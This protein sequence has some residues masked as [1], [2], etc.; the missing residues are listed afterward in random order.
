MS[1]YSVLWDPPTYYPSLGCVDQVNSW[2]W[3]P[4]NGSGASRAA[5]WPSSGNL[6]ENPNSIFESALIDWWAENLIDDFIAYEVPHSGYSLYWDWGEASDGWNV[7]V[8]YDF[9]SYQSYTG[10]G[11]EMHL[12]YCPDDGELTSESSSSSSSTE[13]SLTSSSSSSSSTALSYTSTSHSSLSTEASYTSSSSSTEARESSS[14]SST[15]VSFTSSSS[16][17]GLESSTSVSSQSYSSDSRSSSSTEDSYTSESSSYSSM[18]S[19]SSSSEL[20]G[21]SSSHSGLY[22]LRSTSSLSSLGLSE[23]SSSSS[24]TVEEEALPVIDGH[25]VLPHQANWASTPSVERQWRSGVTAALTGKEDRTSIRAAAWIK[26]KYQVLPYNHDERAR[27]D[28]RMKA[29]M[30]AGKVAVPRWGKGVSIASA[31]VAGDTVLTLNRTS[32][33]FSNGQ[34]VFVQSSTPTE[35]MFWDICLIVSVDRSVITVAT[36]LDHGY[37]EGTMVWPILY[38]RPIPEDFTIMNK[39]RNQYSVSLQYDQRQVNA[40]ASEDFE[41]YDD[42]VIVSSL[43]GGIGW[44]GPWVI[45]AMAA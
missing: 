25:Y 18:T 29:A 28:Y 30:K 9:D 37:P 39:S 21:S 20:I 5:R 24:S 26:M 8:L 2:R 15:V 11:W 19:S 1:V 43:S 35:Y 45:G 13:V 10:A 33:G 4:D 41:S 40:Y 32:H 7:D 31:V 12:A 3:E 34:Y 14:S 23:S 16:S 36:P 22:F 38:G 44:E 17:I 27:F 42:G 6:E